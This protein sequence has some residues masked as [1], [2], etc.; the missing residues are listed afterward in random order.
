MPYRSGTTGVCVA[1]SGR[2]GIEQGTIVEHETTPED[3][4]E[5]VND[6]NG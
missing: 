1:C 5:S 2:F 3:E 4:R 6:A